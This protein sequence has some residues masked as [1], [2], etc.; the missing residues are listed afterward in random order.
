MNPTF[1]AWSLTSGNYRLFFSL[2]L[3]AILSRLTLP[4][5]ISHLPN[6]SALDAIAL[7]CGAYCVRR[8]G[9][10]LTVFAAVAISDFVLNKILMG[11]WQLFYPGF[12][13]QYA[14][15]ALITLLG[16]TLSQQ[17]HLLRLGATC[18]MA[19]GLFF[20]ISNFGVWCSGLLYPYSVEGLVA[21][22]I[23]A[24]PFFKNTLC[25]DF[26]FAAFL[27]GAFEL[28]KIKFCHIRL[29]TTAAHLKLLK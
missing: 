27:F 7:F 29:L 23:A 20:V 3:L 21:C 9:A 18:F 25:S 5:L 1:S 16:A 4:P 12:Y 15:Y 10:L 24:I 2:I 13:W 8:T 19:A 11:Q 26:F 17:I 22:Y 28:A 14:C 6:F